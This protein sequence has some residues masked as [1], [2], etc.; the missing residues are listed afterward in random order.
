MTTI[1]N[2]SAMESGPTEKRHLPIF[3]SSTNAELRLRFLGSWLPIL[4]NM[5]EYKRKH[6]NLE[7]H[8][9]FSSIMQG[10]YDVLDLMA[11]IFGLYPTDQSESNQKEYSQLIQ[12]TLKG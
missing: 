7:K 4:R 11:G 8:Q 2:K 1:A 9:L 12:D 10:N 3:A 6:E 5:F